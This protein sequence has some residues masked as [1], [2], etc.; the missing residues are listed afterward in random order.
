MI[1]KLV[2]T[3]IDDKWAQ[4]IVAAFDVAG[5]S[6]DGR[7]DLGEQD[8]MWQAVKNNDEFIATIF[9][10]LSGGSTPVDPT[11]PATLFSNTRKAIYEVMDKITAELN[12]T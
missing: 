6:A 7:L 5:G 9:D 10:A 11:G 8:K 12:A 3:Q 2:G 1:E 4:D